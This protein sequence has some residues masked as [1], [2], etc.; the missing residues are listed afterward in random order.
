MPN[1]SIDRALQTVDE[2]PETINLDEG[3]NWEIEYTE[4]FFGTTIQRK[5]IRLNTFLKTGTQDDVGEHCFRSQI[6]SKMMMKTKL[7]GKNQMNERDLFQ[8]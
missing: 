4:D 8:K 6:F 3:T 5:P 1:F 7:K 2:L